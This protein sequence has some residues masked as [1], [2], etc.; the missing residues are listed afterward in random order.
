MQSGNLGNP[1]CTQGVGAHAREA[2]VRRAAIHKRIVDGK[3]SGVGVSERA[4]YPSR[5]P[6][7]VGGWL[8]ASRSARPNVRLQYQPHNPKAFTAD[9]HVTNNPCVEA[10]F[11]DGRAAVVDNAPKIL[12]FMDI[13]TPSAVVREMDGRSFLR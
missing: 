7:Y 5:L 4:P 10:S 1:L 12:H 13:P 8:P 9:E 6:S 3:G 2:R 11:R